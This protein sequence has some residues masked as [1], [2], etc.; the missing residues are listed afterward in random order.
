MYRLNRIYGVNVYKYI[1]YTNSSIQAEYTGEH[2][3]KIVFCDCL[4]NGNYLYIE[5]TA[6]GK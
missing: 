4:R 5:N 1:D 2:D 3:N 6:M